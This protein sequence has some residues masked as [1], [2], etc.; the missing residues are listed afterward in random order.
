LKK[1][2]QPNAL[3]GGFVEE[4][5]SKQAEMKTGEGATM[6]QGEIRLKKSPSTGHR[7]R[8]G[9]GEKRKKQK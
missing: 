7:P 9:T 3:A 1:N 6:T 8:A 4:K 5:I 2:S